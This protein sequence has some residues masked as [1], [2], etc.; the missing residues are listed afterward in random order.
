[1][2]SDILD[3]CIR[4]FTPAKELV[5]VTHVYRACPI[6]FIGFSTSAELVILDMTNFDIILG[7][8]FLSLYY[9][10]LN[11]Y[12]KYVTQEIMKRENL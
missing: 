6:L 1:M 5:K 10:V 9:V 3:T 11:C 4:V 7:M 2:I 12:T 8:N